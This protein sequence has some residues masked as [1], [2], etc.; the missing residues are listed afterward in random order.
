[1]P[2]IRPNTEYGRWDAS[3]L[4]ASADGSDDFRNTANTFGWVVEI[5][6]YNPVSTP[7][8]HTALGRFAHE[9]AWP[10]NP[11]VGKPLRLLHGRRFAQRVRLQ[12]RL[13]RPRGS[14]ADA[15]GGTGSRGNKYLDDGTLYAR[16]FNADGTA[17][18]SSST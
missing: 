3:K 18:G 2:P 14:A 13:E 15:N 16:E 10:G 12:V 8:K 17:P 4:G 9:G 5:D 7:R 6:P 11:V 1:M